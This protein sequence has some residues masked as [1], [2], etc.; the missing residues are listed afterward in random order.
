[1]PAA[2]LER[3]GAAPSG[4][5]GGG[6]GRGL[7]GPCRREGAFVRSGVACAPHA[8]IATR[9]DLAR[10]G[11]ALLPGILKTARLG[12]DGKG[13]APVADRAALV[14][15]WS[16]LGGV[17]CVLEKRLPL[18]AEISVVVARDARRRGRA[19]A[20]AATTSIATASS[21]SRAC[22]RARSSARRR[23]AEAI[24][25]AERLAAALDYVGVLCVEF[26]V[27][28]GGALVANEMAPRPH[29]SGH[30]SIDACDVSQFD[31]QVRTMTGA[32]LVAPR[33]HSAAVMLNLLGDLWQRRR[34]APDWARCS[35]C[36]AR[37]CTSTAR[38]EARPG[39]KMG[40]LT[41]TAA[42]AARGAP[43]DAALRAR[44]RCGLARGRRR[45]A[46]CCSTASTPRRSTAPPRASPP[47][48]WSRF[49]TETV[50]GLGARADDDAAVAQDLRAKGRPAGPSAD[51]PRC[52]RGRRAGASPRR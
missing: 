47:A 13:Q 5:A 39:R 38:R 34:R 32:P 6:S 49:P 19:P 18:A 25:L 27:L 24:A 35:R 20:G 43:R 1:M 26:F 41:I 12:Y 36:P 51:R 45:R 3:A 40:H 46:T 42:T 15:A 50:Y 4:R 28:D 23:S 17:P 30:Y 2:A 10:V 44:P 21:P 52:R 31:L 11:D 29:N 22:R 48:S 16:A 9:G 14:A 7:P 33:R 37:I 8:S